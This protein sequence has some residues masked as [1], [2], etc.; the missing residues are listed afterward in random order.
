MDKKYLVAIAYLEGQSIAIVKSF[1]SEEVAQAWVDGFN[2]AYD[3]TD[4][5]C[6]A[7]IVDSY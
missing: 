6:F 3:N 7:A 5:N 1:D 2:E 4:L